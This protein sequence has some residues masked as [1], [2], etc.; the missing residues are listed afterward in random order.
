MPLALV[1]EN[2]KKALKEQPDLISKPV[3][4][5]RPTPELVLASGQLV[6][7]NSKGHLPPKSKNLKGSHSQLSF[8]ASNDEDAYQ[9]LEKKCLN[10]QQPGRRNSKIPLYPTQNQN[11]PPSKKSQEVKRRDGSRSREPSR[12]T[13]MDQG[14]IKNHIVPVRNKSSPPKTRKF[15]DFLQFAKETK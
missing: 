1:I 5:S 15:G 8:D 6:H 14:P 3:S 12:P 2:K 10:Q 9:L 4:E 7:S 13:L 11:L